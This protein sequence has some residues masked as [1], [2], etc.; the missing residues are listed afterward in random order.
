MKLSYRDRVILVIALVI[1]II[2]VGIFAFI[3]PKAADIKKNDER[4][5][6]V[7]ATWAEYEK[8]FEQIPVMQTNIKNLHS[9]AKK[10]AEYFTEQRTSIQLDE[11]VQKYI[12]DCEMKLAS[13]NPFTVSDPTVAPLSFYYYTPSSLT[14][15]LYEN[16]DLDGSLHTAAKE[17]MK[18]SSV[19]A[20]RT[21]RDVVCSTAVFTG[22]ATK[23]NLMKFLKAIK[24]LD[25]TIL[26]TNVSI[27]DYSFY[28]EVKGDNLT[29]EARA[30]LEEMKDHSLVAIE[31]SFYSVQVPTDPYIGPETES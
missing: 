20:S 13:G 25:T 30:K 27:N 17:A 4:L 1:L 26:V 23:E 12:D 5:E 24:D 18:E 29:P 11:F 19:L 16:A 21:T 10:W 9:E 14:Y 8:Q 22:T 15:P 6:D 3:K 31:L 28:P 2:G 7:Q